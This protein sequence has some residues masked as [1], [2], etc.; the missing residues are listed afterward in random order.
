MGNAHTG[1][2]GYFVLCLLDNPCYVATSQLPVL[3]SKSG[4]AK[5]HVLPYEVKFTFLREKKISLKTP[6]QRTTTAKMPHIYSGTECVFER[7]T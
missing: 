3:P 7:Q 5:D 1:T 2:G 6:Y 4:R